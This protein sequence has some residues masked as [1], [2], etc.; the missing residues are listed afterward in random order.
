M[1]YLSLPRIHDFK[2]FSRKSFDKH[3]NFA[4]GIKDHLIFTELS[5]DTIVKNRGLNIMFTI[6]N[7]KTQDQAC[8]LLRGFEFPIK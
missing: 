7:A 6:E 5:Y 4:F 2:G 8:E 3:N 1:I